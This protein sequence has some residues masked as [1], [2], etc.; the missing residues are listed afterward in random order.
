MRKQECLKGVREVVICSL[1]C[2]YV[3]VQRVLVRNRVHG[4]S[5]QA[6]FLAGADDAHGNLSTIGDEH[7][8]EVLG[9]H[10]LELRPTLWR[11]DGG[12]DLPLA[13]AAGTI[14][15]S[16]PMHLLHHLRSSTSNFQKCDPG[17]SLSSIRISVDCI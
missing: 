8:L 17:K 6:E 12:G 3:D 11:P 7:L 2:A 1:S 4:D 16:R 9:G 15:L 14:E 13:T 10:C 5:L